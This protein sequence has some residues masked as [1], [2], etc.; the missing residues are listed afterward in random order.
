M[1]S[2]KFFFTLSI[3][4]LLFAC[5]K[6][7]TVETEVANEPFVSTETTLYSVTLP[8]D[9]AAEDVAEWFNQL[10]EAQIAEHATII[11]GEAT[12]KSCAAWS[13]WSGWFIDQQTFSCQSKTCPDPQSQEFISK[14][15]SRTRECAH[16]TE[17]EQQVVN[18][19]TC[20]PPC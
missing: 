4:C 8:K 1:K 3:L 10:T 6:N 14:R 19:T 15:R 9:V 18:T 13:S 16:G 11:D 2:I 20:Y 5:S 7:Q 17:T 12:Q